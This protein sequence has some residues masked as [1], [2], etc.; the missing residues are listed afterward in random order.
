MLTVV[1]PEQKSTE[2]RAQTLRNRVDWW[3]DAYAMAGVWANVGGSRRG[4]PAFG[5]QP[6]RRSEFHYCSHIT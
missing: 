2:Q 6:S 4:T 3:S 1:T 5:D